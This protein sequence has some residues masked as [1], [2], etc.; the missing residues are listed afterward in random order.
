VLDFGLSKEPQSGPGASLT[1]TD[2]IF[3]TPQYMSPEQI[4]STK[5]VDAR[6]DQHALAMILFELIT[7]RAAF[8]APNVSH[9]IV[10]IA[11]A[12]PPR[13]RDIRSDIPAKLEQALL[14]AL[15]KRPDDRFANL[16][17][18][19]EAI[20]P[21][22]GPEAKQMVKHVRAA[23]TPR[24]SLTPV[25]PPRPSSPRSDELTTAQLGPV[26]LAPAATLSGSTETLQR[27][28]RTPRIA[29]AV[30]VVGTLL[31]AVV[32]A[33]LLA[34]R[35][36]ESGGESGAV[37]AVAE[38]ISATEQGTPAIEAPQP[39]PAEMVTPSGT[40]SAASAAS[41]ATASA[42]PEKKTRSTGGGGH[43]AAPKPAVSSL[44]GAFGERKK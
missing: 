36:G 14:R 7:G 4:R 25:P 27:S 44:L 22:G 33:I 31:V 11:T 32:V 30:A 13:I 39:G 5:N 43:A 40:A 28:Q 6:T 17:D 10:L 16:A 9:L 18:F 42:G 8:D 19:A 23:L 1:A 24:D 12:P 15:A 20:A 26:R 3:G 35:S 2:S 41:P 21:F 37:P 29:V 34:W 38:P